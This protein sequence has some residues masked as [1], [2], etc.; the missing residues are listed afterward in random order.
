MIA[1]DLYVSTLPRLG[2][3]VVVQIW[4]IGT[5]YSFSPAWRAESL[6]IE[7]P[8]GS[9]L[10]PTPGLQG[11]ARL[12]VPCGRLVRLAWDAGD[13]ARAAGERRGA[14]RVV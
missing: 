14:F 3:A 5:G 7:A 8:K 2:V 12:F 10:L 11:R 6:L 4:R 1:L 13:V 9:E